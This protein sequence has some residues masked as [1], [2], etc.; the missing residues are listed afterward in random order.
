M[1]ITDN[2]F[3]AYRCELYRGIDAM[4][5]ADKQRQESATISNKK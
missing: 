1:L 4:D 5:F 3:L 2:G